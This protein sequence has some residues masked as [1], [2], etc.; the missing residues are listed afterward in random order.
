MF[1]IILNKKVLLRDHKRHTA[2][3]VA[4]TRCAVLTGG[5]GGGYP[6]PILVRGYPILSCPG[7]GGGYPIPVLPHCYLSPGMEYSPPGTGVSP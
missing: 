7:R 4:S 6:H 2:C 1:G 3:R 5:V